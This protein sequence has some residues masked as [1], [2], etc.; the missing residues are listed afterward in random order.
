M[1]NAEVA[2]S[3]VPATSMFHY[4]LTSSITQASK[5]HKILRRINFH[6]QNEGWIRSGSYTD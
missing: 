6:R 4:S 1:H 2:G 5:T 3:Y